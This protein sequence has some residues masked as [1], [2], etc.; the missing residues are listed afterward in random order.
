MSGATVMWR[1]VEGEFVA[2]SVRSEIDC[3]ALSRECLHA[4]EPRIL[5]RDT[6][7]ADTNE[8]RIVRTD[9]LNPWFDQADLLVDVLQGGSPRES[10][11]GFMTAEQLSALEGWYYDFSGTSEPESTGPNRMLVRAPVM[12]RSVEDDRTPSM[13]HLEFALDSGVWRLASYSIREGESNHK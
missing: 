1:I 9:V 2:L 8:L 11:L 7:S 12:R 6:L 13:L 10:V 3:R 5:V 4:G